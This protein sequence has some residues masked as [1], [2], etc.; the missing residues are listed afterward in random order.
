MWTKTGNIKG[1]QGLS[2]PGLATGGTANQFLVKTGASDFQ[3]GWQARKRYWRLF[4]DNSGDNVNA[5][6]TVFSTVKSPVFT[7]PA[8]GWYKVTA[9]FGIFVSANSVQ[10]A[11]ALMIDSNVGQMFYFTGSSGAHQPVTIVV[12][13][14]LTTG[15]KVTIG[16]RP[17]TSGR[18]V[19][20][21]NSN[22]VIPLLLVE[23][24]DAPQ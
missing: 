8:T 20:L 5:S 7:A 13:F 2:G 10:S 6:T 21:V 12:P 1:L 19:T 3:T 15:Q 18:T 16:Y 23:E 22:T 9:N 14:S 17:V 11:V 4:G 24:V